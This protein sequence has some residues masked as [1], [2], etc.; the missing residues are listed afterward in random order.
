MSV[1][2][3]MFVCIFECLI[4]S[5]WATSTLTYERLF[6]LWAICR[7]ASKYSIRY[8]NRRLHDQ[9]IPLTTSSLISHSQNSFSLLVALHALIRELINSHRRSIVKRTP[10]T[11]RKSLIIL[12]VLDIENLFF[13]QSGRYIQNKQATFTKNMK[14]TRE[15]PRR[16]KER[17][18]FQQDRECSQQSEASMEQHR[19]SV[20]TYLPS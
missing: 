7:Y 18:L 19:T 3:F 5:P 16:R 20:L 10:R 11:V 13:K 4:A 9:Q 14:M 12:A 6:N 15:Q 1:V 17:V 2:V 8:H